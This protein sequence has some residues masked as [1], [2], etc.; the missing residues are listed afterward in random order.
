M[1]YVTPSRSNS[2]PANATPA[3]L[4]HS[5]IMRRAESLSICAVLHWKP[6]SHMAGKT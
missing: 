1:K 5:F 4:T 6:A 3:G 2:C